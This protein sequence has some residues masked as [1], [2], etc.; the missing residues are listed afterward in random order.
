M[1]DRGVNMFNALV[2]KSKTSSTMSRKKKAS[3]DDMLIG[4][5]D[6]LKYLNT[7]EQSS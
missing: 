3:L 5:A 2:I 7:Y 4:Y 6:M 1:L